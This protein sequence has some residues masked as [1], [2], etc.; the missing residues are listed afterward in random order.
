MKN[1]YEV[2]GVSRDAS[3]DEIK[4]A[5]RG[6]SR[7][8][9]PDANVNNPN[10]EQA[11]ERFKEVQAAYEE[12]MNSDRNSYKTASSGNAGY[13]NKNGFRGYGNQTD[14][15]GAADQDELYINAAFRFV[16]NGLYREAITVLYH[17]K[18][19]SARY[20]YAASL[21]DMGLGNQVEALEHIRIAISMEPDNMVYQQYL[22]QLQRGRQWYTARGMEYGNFSDMGNNVCMRRGAIDLAF[23]LCCGM[24]FCCRP[25][26]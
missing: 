25:V 23:F 9:H 22:Q 13:G 12:I 2:L 10:K 24:R 3:D 7:K 15:K 8:Y 11:E 16:E 1:P 26:I 21:A 4:K 6:L 20:Y 14:T 18:N 19:K 5:Y 17:V